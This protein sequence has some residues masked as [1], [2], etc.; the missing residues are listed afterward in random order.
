MPDT[1]VQGTVD[2]GQGDSGTETSCTQCDVASSRKTE[3]AAESGTI[4]RCCVTLLLLLLSLFFVVVVVRSVL[5]LGT[6]QW[7]GSLLL[8]LL[9]LLFCELFADKWRNWYK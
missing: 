6:A 2:T 1:M 8:L 4:F 3:A 7:V 5:D 9:L